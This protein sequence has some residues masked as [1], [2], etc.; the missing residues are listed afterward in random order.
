M[1]GLVFAAAVGRHVWHGV[2]QPL[3]CHSAPLASWC[4]MQAGHR[5][6]S[7]PN[8]HDVATMAEPRPVSCH[9]VTVIRDVIRSD[10]GV[11]RPFH[12]EAAVDRTSE[13][14]TNSTSHAQF[15][16]DKLARV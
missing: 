2:R 8:V 4:T 13:P 12:H 15:C 11:I 14:P 1:D 9:C 5:P 7:D 3:H 6:P 16:G 10:F